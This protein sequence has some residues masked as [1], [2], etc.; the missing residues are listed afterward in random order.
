MDVQ[1]SSESITTHPVEACVASWH[2]QMRK[3]LS[4]IA[5]QNNA[6]GSWQAFTIRAYMS[7]G[8]PCENHVG[9]PFGP[10]I[11]IASIRKL[12]YLF[13][14]GEANSETVRGSYCL[15]V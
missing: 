7:L 5:P 3:D 13:R 14:N 15:F 2:L 4:C 8:I 12:H 1:T 11:K 6:A 10:I 9:G